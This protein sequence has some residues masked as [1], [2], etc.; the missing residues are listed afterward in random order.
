MAKINL[1]PWRLERR[2]QKQK[3]FVTMLG[4]AAAIAIGLSVL[5]VFYYNGQIS[6]QENRNNYL[7][8]E[9]ANIDKQIE[10]IKDLEKKK[11]DLLS[12]KKAIECLQGRRSLMVHLF[13]DLVRTI[14]DG[15]KLTS[16]EQDGS[17][18]TVNGSSQSNAR[19]SAYMRNLQVSGWMT[20]PELTIIEAKGGDKGLPYQFTL[21]TTIGN[22]NTKTD[23]GEEVAAV[24]TTAAP[25]A[26]A[27]PAAP[28]PAATPVPAA[29]S[30]DDCDLDSGASAGGSP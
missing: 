27:A 19:V 13:D 23:A 26:G 1:L 14:P 15:V 8:T 6:G 24:A 3:E 29:S 25:V 22:P 5:I 10:D 21:I 17:K 16:L 4:T 18:L 2:K 11:S 12:R 9:I 7:T 30:T 20:Q 28:A